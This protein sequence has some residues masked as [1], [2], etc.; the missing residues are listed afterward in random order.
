MGTIM[1][2]YGPGDVRYDDYEERVL[3]SGEVRILTL[4]SG[5]SA[6][7]EM[8]HYRGTNPFR[9]KKYDSDSKLF[10]DEE[11]KSYYPRGTGYEE[12]GKI[13]EIADDVSSVETGMIVYGQWQHRSSTILPAEIAAK[14]VLPDGLDPICGIF[15]QIGAIAYNGI[16]DAQINVG[17]TVLVMG[18]GIPGLITTQLAHLSG[19]RVIAA[20]LHQ[21]RLEKA[22]EVGADVVL[23]AAEVN[24]AQEVKRLT[25]NRGADV[26]IEVSGNTHALAT[27]IKACAYSGRTVALGFYQ[28][29][30]RGLFLGEEFHHNRIEIVCSQISGIHPRFSYRWDMDRFYST[31]MQLQLS[32]KLKLK[33]LITHTASFRDTQSLYKNN[34]RNTDGR[35]SGSIGFRR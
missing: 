6:G 4:F 29:E 35:N 18:Q 5:I 27:C 21:M 7:T 9:Y 23:N 30:A 14:H 15:S 34:R 11:D 22:A 26:C 28:N 16:L 17:E 25:G 12:I 13:V 20:D 33:E 24:V 8:S 31:V 3:K 1:R 2:F 19:A 10:S 32:G